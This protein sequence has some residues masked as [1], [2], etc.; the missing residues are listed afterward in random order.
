MVLDATG[1]TGSKAT[2]DDAHQNEKQNIQL[3]YLS[4]LATMCGGRLVVPT[5][6]GKRN[7]VYNR[8]LMLT[9]Q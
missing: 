7:V 3:S 8:L 2:A 1:V 6:V 4:S 5:T 9:Q